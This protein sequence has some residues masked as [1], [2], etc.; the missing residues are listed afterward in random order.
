VRRNRSSVGK[1]EKEEKR[2][3]G[4]DGERRIGEGKRNGKTWRRVV[5]RRWRQVEGV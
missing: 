3:A 2:E 5:K 1:V 4:V